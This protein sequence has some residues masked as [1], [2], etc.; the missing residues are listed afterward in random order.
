MEISA[1]LALRRLGLPSDSTQATVAKTLDAATLAV[2]IE[3]GRDAKT[4]AQAKAHR[5]IM[6][7]LEH[8]RELFGC[9][10]NRGGVA[11]PAHPM[12]AGCWCNGS[13]VFALYSK[14]GYS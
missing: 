8:F 9:T 10:I 11:E 3:Y 4:A 7:D 14:Y 12:W 13:V 5:A 2:V 6:T 1:S